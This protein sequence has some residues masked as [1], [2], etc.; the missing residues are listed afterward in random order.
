MIVTC[1]EVFVKKER[2]DDFIT[3]IVD[4]HENSIKEPGNLRF[5]VLQSKGDPTKF[6][7]IEAY[8]SEESAKAHKDTAHYL[9][10]RDTVG[11]WMAKPR[12]GTPCNVIAPTDRNRW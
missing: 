10:W 2:V 6:M 12:V 9:K 1:V 4:N 5:D 8:E 3:A 11:D 7:L